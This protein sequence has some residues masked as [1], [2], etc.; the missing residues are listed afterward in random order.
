MADPLEP[1]RLNATDLQWV[2]LPNGI[3]RAYVVGDEKKAGV[4]AYFAK[5]PGN[6]KTQ[7]H[8]HPDE[9]V[10]TVISGTVRFGYG[11]RFDEAAMKDVTVGG[12]WTEPAKQPHFAWVKDGEAVVYVVGFGPSGTKEVSPA[13]DKK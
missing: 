1:S 13:A 9:R 10:V 2:V 3:S 12:F 5:L 6:S 4:Y 7:P 11:E 8:W